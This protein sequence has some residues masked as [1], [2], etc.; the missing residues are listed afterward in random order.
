M[1]WLLGHLVGDYLLQTDWQ[2]VN[3]KKPGLIGWVACLIHCITWT[4]SVLIFTDWWS[5]KLVVLIFLSHIVLDRTQLVKVFLKIARK[6]D[7]FWL[8]IVCDNTIHLVFLWLIA[9]YLS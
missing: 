9:K 3:K 6:K 1:D 4:V 7:D 5:P 8:I 2:A